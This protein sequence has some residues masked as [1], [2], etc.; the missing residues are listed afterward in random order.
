MSPSPNTAEGIAVV[1]EDELVIFPS[2]SYHQVMQPWTGSMATEI[3]CL[4]NLRSWLQE[5]DPLGQFKNVQHTRE[6]RDFTMR[7]FIQSSDNK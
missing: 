6:K 1:I 4:D 5:N 2:A 7:C 3:H